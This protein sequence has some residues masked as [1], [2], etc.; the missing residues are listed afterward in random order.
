MQLFKYLTILSCLAVTIFFVS[1][2]KTDV[3]SSAA[4]MSAL[5]V[6]PDIIKDSSLLLAK[7][8]YIW[9]NQIPSTLDARS[10]A[11]PGKIME[12]LHPYSIEAGFSQ[13]VDRWSFGMKK[14]EWDNISAGISSTFSGSN[15]SGDF[16]FGVM[17][18][19]DGDL[20]IKSVERESPAGLAGIRR[21]WRVVKIN[22][23]TNM[24]TSNASFI[25]DNVYNATTSSFTFITPDGTSV[26]MNFNAT[27]YHKHPVILDSVYSISSKH[28]GYFVFNSFLG[29]TTEIYNNFQRIFNKFTNAGVTDVVIDLRYNGGGYVSVQQRLANYLVAPS[30]TNGLMMKEQYNDKN[31]QYNEVTYFRKVGPFSPQHIYFIVS[32]GTASASE[33][34]INNLSPYMDIKLVGPG[35]THGKPVGFFPV[36]VGE[37]YI[38]PVSFKSSNRN[39]EGNYF[40]GIPVNSAVGDGLN[41]DWGD[42]QEACLARTLKS[43]TTGTFA[44]ETQDNYNE[45]VNIQQGNV[46]LDLPSFKGSIDTR[47]MIK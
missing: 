35:A 22:G 14:T 42:I 47:G 9:Y 46:I 10:Y 43:I 20:R 16:G 32:K 31:S 37:W 36:S 29:D 8:L 21:G 6:S 19:V 30:A 11:D 27:S 17:F 39:G 28:I 44:V 2:R 5:V 24:T 18:L 3:H 4:S 23:N 13:P 38:F 7:N 41:K 12:A 33:L 25:V 15:S 26:D 1:C 34:L 45:P 40:N